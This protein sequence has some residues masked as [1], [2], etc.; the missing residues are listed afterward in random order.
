M[1]PN[2]IYASSEDA[3][4]QSGEAQ[5]CNLQKDCILNKC[6]PCAMYVLAGDLAGAALCAI[7]KCPLCC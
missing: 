1:L 7:V 3:S 5:G 6:P 4:S 2:M